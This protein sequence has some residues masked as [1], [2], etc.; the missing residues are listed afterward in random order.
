MLS[1]RASWFP[2]ACVEDGLSHRLSSLLGIESSIFQV[3]VIKLP[4]QLR[5]FV[6]ALIELFQVIYRSILKI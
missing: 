5:K 1:L 2:V 3:T 6:D 4:F